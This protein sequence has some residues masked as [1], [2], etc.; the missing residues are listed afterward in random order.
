MERLVPWNGD[1]PLLP[2]YAH[3]YRTAEEQ[4]TVLLPAKL[5]ENKPVHNPTLVMSVSTTCNVTSPCKISQHNSLSNST[6]LC[7][8]FHLLTLHYPYQIN[9]TNHYAVFFILLSL[10]PCY[11]QT[12]SRS[13]KC[14]PCHLPGTRPG[15]HN[16]LPIIFGS[17]A[18]NLLHVKLL[19]PKV[20]RRFL[21]FAKFVH[22]CTKW[23]WQSRVTSF[24]TW[25]F[26]SFA[27][28]ENVYK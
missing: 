16:V 10:R 20:L 12:Q 26:I 25:T 19:K 15:L 17:S 4:L 5:I 7:H 11:N 24:T 28:F 6:D 18:W 3:E 2:L 23:L 14:T 8:P 27:K 13:A 21:C 22:P 1:T 9:S